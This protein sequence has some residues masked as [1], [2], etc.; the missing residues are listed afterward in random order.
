[1]PG[2]GLRRLVQ[3]GRLGA[4][5]GAGVYKWSGEILKEVTSA[6]ARH[7]AMMFGSAVRS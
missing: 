7:A 1:M 3:S 5:S 6:L 2:V 4:K